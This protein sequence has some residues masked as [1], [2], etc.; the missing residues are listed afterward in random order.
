MQLAQ[1][2]REHLEAGC[3]SDLHGAEVAGSDVVALDAEVTACVSAVITRARTG[4]DDRATQRLQEIRATLERSLVGS[5]G[6]LAEY[7]ARLRSL[8]TAALERTQSP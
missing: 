5:T 4:G 7:F 6:P 2:W 8:V 3:P 1:L